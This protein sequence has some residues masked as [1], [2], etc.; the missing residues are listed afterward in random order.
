MYHAL[1][2][3]HFGP[4]HFFRAGGTENLGGHS[5]ILS[6]H[7]AVSA[8]AILSLCMRKWEVYGLV[9]LL[10]QVSL[11]QILFNTIF[12]RIQHGLKSGTMCTRCFDGTS[13]ASKLINL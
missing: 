6:S 8:Y 2:P 12:S 13:F 7:N 5:V 11:K 9:E 4:I 10:E 1:S 3:P